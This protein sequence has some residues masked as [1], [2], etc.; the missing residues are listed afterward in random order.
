MKIGEILKCCA[1]IKQRGKRYITNYYNKYNETDVDFDVK[2]GSNT[3]VFCLQEAFVYRCFFL[4]SDLY[5]LSELLEQVPTDTVMDYIIK[6]EVLDTE[7]DASFLKAGFNLYSKYQRLTTP[8]PDNRPKTKLIQLMEKMYNPEI[9]VKA[10]ESDA[11]D[12]YNLMLEQFDPR[13]SEIL[14]MSE[15]LDSIRQGRVWIYRVDNEICV[16]YIYQIEGK[17]RYGN[18]TI[19]KLS[20]DYLYNVTTNANNDSLLHND[21]RFHYGWIK[22]DNLKVKKSLQ[23]Q[24]ILDFD[25]VCNFIYI[26]NNGGKEK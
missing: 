2:I 12:I 1:D 23:S 5:E 7:L 21:I 26:K 22:D 19:N 6:S 24:G 20:A 13:G 14:T 16:L 17:K 11:S 4:T 18:M 15:L 25:G 10:V 8:V 3:I 9:G